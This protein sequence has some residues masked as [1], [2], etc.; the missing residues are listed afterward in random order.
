MREILQMPPVLK[1]I[2]SATLTTEMI[3][4]PSLGPTVVQGPYALAILLKTL[5]QNIKFLYLA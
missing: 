5:I 4:S 1:N 2:S 3:N